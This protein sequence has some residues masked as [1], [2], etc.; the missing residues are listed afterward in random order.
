MSKKKKVTRGNPVAVPDT[1]PRG[2][3]KPSIRLGDETA[4]KPQVAK[5]SSK[6]KRTKLNWKQL[7]AFLV[8]LFIGA[9]LILSTLAVPSPKPEAPAPYNAPNVIQSP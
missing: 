1:K 8:V 2:G 3:W 4:P 7:A 5:V 6:P 9:A